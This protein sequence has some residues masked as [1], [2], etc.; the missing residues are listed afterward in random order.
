MD[1]ARRGL[2]RRAALQSAAALAVGAGAALGGDRL[3][4]VS[5][6]APLRT[7]VPFYGRHQAGI[8]TR[9]QAHLHFASFAFDGTRVRDL[10]DLLVGWSEAAAAMSAGEPVQT[11]LASEGPGPADS[12]EALGLDPASLTITVGLGRTLFEQAGRDRLGLRFR[13]PAELAPL[14]RFRGEQLEPRLCGGD[15]CVQACADDPQVAFHA[16]RM[17]AHIASAGGTRVL[18]N[19]V[20]FLRAAG[21]QAAMPRNLLGFKDGTNNILGDD[22]AAMN[23]CV[24]VE[25][26]DEPAWMRGG[27]YLVARRIRIWFDTWDATSLA[28]QERVIGRRKQSGAPLG[29]RY[30]HDAVNLA[31]R[32]EGALVIPATRTSASPLPHRTVAR[33]SCVAAT[34]L[35]IRSSPVTASSTPASS[36]SAT[37]AQSTANS[38]HPREPGDP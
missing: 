22:H 30:E 38:S 1:F 28:E 17:L 11:R 35:P 31:A 16:V 10:R 12:G 21:E 23:R 32:R 29:G 6:N 15:L 19:Q 18:W 14:P 34:R 9:Q 8:A 13:L 36:S 3:S 24:W 26:A 33:G 37:S 7:I 25:A 27:S 2:T 5:P 20:G 4:G